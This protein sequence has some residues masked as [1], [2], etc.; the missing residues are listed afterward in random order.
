MNKVSGSTLWTVMLKCAL[1]HRSSD[2]RPLSLPSTACW[3]QRAAS[4]HAAWDCNQ[5]ASAGPSRRNTG[6]NGDEWFPNFWFLTV[7]PHY[8]RTSYS[9]SAHVK[10]IPVGLLWP[11]P[12]QLVKAPSALPLPWSIPSPSAY[13]GWNQDPKRLAPPT[14]HAWLLA[15]RSFLSTVTILQALGQRS[16][17]LRGSIALWNQ[18]ARRHCLPGEV[19]APPSTAWAEG[20]VLPPLPSLEVISP[21]LLVLPVP[22]LHLASSAKALAHAGAG[23]RQGRDRGQCWCD[24]TE[25]QKVETRGHEM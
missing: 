6:D 1:P 4:T 2:S 8:K 9:E 18:G 15:H 21:E 24:R 23:E 22:S 7:K 20:R 19:W 3:P 5:A 16:L 14:S 12:W 13:G 10:Q 25:R 11:E 17:H